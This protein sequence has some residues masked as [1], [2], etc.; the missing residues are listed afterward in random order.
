MFS[1]VTFNG[2]NIEPGDWQSLLLLL[3]ITSNV[4]AHLPNRRSSTQ[5]LYKN[6]K[7]S[8]FIII[9]INVMMIVLLLFIVTIDCNY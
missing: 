7:S 8:E 9:T 2:D 6:L 1:T 4:K 5:I 3:F